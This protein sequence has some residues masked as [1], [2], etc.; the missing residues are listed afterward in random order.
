MTEN[1]HV[2]WEHEAFFRIGLKSVA[3]TALKSLD[4]SLNASV[5]LIGIPINE[6]DGAHLEAADHFW[7]KS[8]DF[9]RVRSNASEIEKKISSIKRQAS[10]VLAVQ[11]YTEWLKRKSIQEAIKIIIDN[12][13]EKPANKTYWVSI[14]IRVT[15]YWVCAVIGLKTEILN[16]FASLPTWELEAGSYFNIPKAKSLIE[17]LVDE[18]LSMAE[19]QL[20]VTSPGSGFFDYDHEELIRSAGGRLM[21]SIG[22][23]LGKAEKTQ[24]LF[25]TINTISSLRYEGSDGF[26]NIVLAKKQHE[27]IKSVVKFK[28]PIKLAVSRGSRKLLELSSENLFLHTDGVEVMGLVS[29]ENNEESMDHIF[30]VKILGHYHW[31]IFQAGKVLMRVLSGQPTLAQKQF[32]ERKLSLLLSKIFN[33]ISAQQIDDLV[34]LVKEAEKEAHGTILVISQNAQAESLRLE[35]QG[36]PLVPCK[37]TPHLLK[38][39]TPIDGALILSPDAICYSIGTILDGRVNQRGDATRGAR[40]NSAIRYVDDSEY[41]CMAIVVSEDGGVTFLPEHF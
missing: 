7:A 23:R 28:T 40:F 25:R 26:G 18:L 32:N 5:F 24:D 41:P 3:D 37:L 9:S 34:E 19:E 35:N 29:T 27:K 33:N 30:H 39:L 8:S 13:H 31:E 2:I 6:A 17:A 36:T 1:E 20:A 21:A 22:V 12:H 38:H 16:N 11:R 15:H 4:E 14:P 10:D